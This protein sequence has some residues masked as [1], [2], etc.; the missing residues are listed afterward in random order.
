[1]D[2]KFFRTILFISMSLI[3]NLNLNPAAHA[4]VPLKQKISTSRTKS[5][6]EKYIFNFQVSDKPPPGFESLNISHHNKIDVYYEDKF[7]GSFFAT[8]N[9]DWIEFE[10]T[11]TIVEKLTDITEK[12][13]ISKA[14]SSKLKT[15]SRYICS[16]NRNKSDCKQFVP[17]IAG[18]VFNSNQ[19]RADI[20]I[21][22]QFV[23]EAVKESDFLP[24]SDAGLSFASQL[25]GV[26]SGSDNTDE[27]MDYTLFSN[28]TFAYKNGRINAFFSYE[29]PNSDSIDNDHFSSLQIRD[30]N[31]SF[32]H[33]EYAYQAGLIETD[34]DEFINNE[35][36]LGVSYGTT[37]D[38]LKN[39][40]L[41]AA[42][43]IE[44]FL[45]LPSQVNIYRD[46]RLLSSKFYE[47]GHQILDTESLPHG[48][49]EITV[50]T[51]DTR[52]ITRQEKRYF[53]KTFKMAPFGHPQYHLQLGLLT[54]YTQDDLW[55]N[56]QK[57][58]IYRADYTK[59]LSTSWGIGA[60]FTGDDHHQYATSELY[61]VRHNLEIS[62]SFLVSVNKDYGL[63]CNATYYGDQF[64]ANFY[65]RKIWA[66][67]DAKTDH[68]D[69][70]LQASLQSYLSLSYHF[71]K[72]FISF[73]GNTRKNR[74]ESLEYAY[75]PKID[76]DLFN[77]NRINIKLN[78][79]LNKSQDDFVG[80]AQ[81]II[82]QYNQSWSN[83]LHTG[84][85]HIN[86]NDNT[87]QKGLFGRAKV[88]WDN[89]GVD[90]NGLGVGARVSEEMAGQQSFGADF[91]YKN[92]IGKVEGEVRHIR[93]K[94]ANNNTQYSGMF[95]TKLI[96]AGA[97]AAF[98]ESSQTTGTLVEV[99]TKD[100]GGQFEVVVDN[101]NYTTISSNQVVHIPLHAYD[102]YKIAVADHSKNN[103]YSY[104]QRPKVITL[105]KGN[106]KLLS[107]FARQKIIVFA[108]VIDPNGI[109]VE[110]ALVVKGSADDF[111]L[112]DEAGYLYTEIFEN[113]KRLILQKSD[114]SRC[115]IM[116][117]KTL[118]VKQGLTELGDIICIPM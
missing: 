23:K 54:P 84:Y 35:R 63:A 106:Y 110:N 116:L 70:I 60:S 18:I 82:N 8:Y 24:N 32:E 109:P 97:K 64:N 115:M 11:P 62:P 49:Y 34:G 112:T 4:T 33:G 113:V 79:S 39:K 98:G 85:Q 21:N 5:P 59:R 92:H 44:I 38:T 66:A 93:E 76:F 48:S 96:V 16:P 40:N 20:F 89:Q 99:V 31:G 14:L 69:P 3:L 65:V 37:L 74:G 52:G 41:V 28:N 17:K 111:S 67:H 101:Q 83:N 7:V 95:N 12:A 57:H 102:T 103:F 90:G 73:S 78:L 118:H 13:A 107:W 51:K 58:W 27:D 87:D 10:D 68:Y 45:S 2:K 22:P 86:Y 100:E 104:D 105:Y 81:I 72:V 25:E 30:L 88:H 1:M 6:Q 77:K 19:F 56:V 114:H 47:A 71:D 29:N 9:F 55:P 75:G 26:I 80:L 36:V 61:Y 53:T 42:N 50:E 43:T 15:N 94:S 108:R 91:D 46:G 117:P